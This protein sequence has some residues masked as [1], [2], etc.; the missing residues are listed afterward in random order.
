MRVY[1]CDI[2]FVDAGNEIGVSSKY[3]DITNIFTGPEPINSMF[4]CSFI[5]KVTLDIFEFGAGV[6]CL[7]L[8]E[9]T[10][11]ISHRLENQ[12][13]GEWKMDIG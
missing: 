13:I 4:Q 6:I 11:E 9:G 3:E 10:D 12:E 5:S 8:N 1:G 7:T 2:G